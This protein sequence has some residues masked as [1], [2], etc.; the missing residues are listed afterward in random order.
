MVKQPHIHIPTRSCRCHTHRHTA[1][2]VSRGNIP[3]AHL[4]TPPSGKEDAFIVKR[5]REGARNE[6]FLNLKIP[7]KTKEKRKKDCINKTLV[8]NKYVILS[9]GFSY[10]LF[11]NKIL[12][13]KRAAGF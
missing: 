4:A 12:T 7:T 13:S 8:A 11:Q 6:A 3:A 9:H 5:E 1:A 10:L 2:N